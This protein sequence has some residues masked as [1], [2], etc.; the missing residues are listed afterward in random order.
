VTGTGTGTGTGTTSNDEKDD[1]RVPDA[2][3]VRDC[4]GVLAL[5]R[6]KTDPRRT[7]LVANTHLFW[8]P[9]CADVKLSQAE[10]LCAEVAHFMREHE[11]KLSPGES[12]ASTP[13]IIA[14]DFNSVPGSEVHARMLRGIIPG[15][16]DGGGVGRRLRSAYAAAAAAGVVRSDPGSKTM[17]IETG[18]T[19]TEELKPAPTRPETG[20]PAH[21]NVTPG[22]TDCIDYV[23]VSDGVD[24]TAAEPLPAIEH[25][26]E[27]LPNENHPSD[28]LPVTVDL[29]F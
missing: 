9:T 29:A 22:F 10:R 2:R 19:G 4:V 1:E 25:L 14:G 17:M 7:V 23:F 5:L 24:V 6:T 26:G 3:H 15:V 28:H 27:G 20:E 12:V 16:E 18:E 11:D 13:V 21:T 8:D